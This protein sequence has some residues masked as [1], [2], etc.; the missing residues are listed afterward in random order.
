MA[1]VQEI[2]A[3]NNRPGDSIK[4]GEQTYGITI[5]ASP[6]QRL[7]EYT[8]LDNV[9]KTKAKALK[10]KEIAT[11][12]GK[13]MALNIN[14]TNK[15]IYDELDKQKQEILYLVTNNKDV[16]DYNKN[17]EANKKW[18]ELYGQFTANREKA[19]A[20]DVL[21]NNAVAEI[22]KLP[23]EQ[24][25][26]AREV[27]ENKRS[28][29][30]AGGASNFLK[31]GIAELSA[32]KVEPK[33]F[34][35]PKVGNIQYQTFQEGGN[36]NKTY[37]VDVYDINSLDAASEQAW[38]GLQTDT[39]IPQDNPNNDKTIALQ[40][41]NA[42]IAYNQNRKGLGKFSGET[43]AKTN[44]IIS[45]Y[46][47]AVEKAKTEG[48]SQPQKP[49]IIESIEAINRNIEAASDALQRQA[50]RGGK[51]L[52]PR[53]KTI[54]IE[55]ELQGGE[56]VKLESLAEKPPE[57][58]IKY[59]EKGDDTGNAIKI[60]AQNIDVS[61]SEKDRQ[62][63]WRIANI[64]ASSSGS[65]KAAGASEFSYGPFASI[66]ASIGNLNKTVKLSELSIAQV[67][68]I[69]PAYVSEGKVV[70]KVSDKEVSIGTNKAGELTI[71]E[72]EKGKSTR[73]LSESKVL[74]NASSWLATDAKDKAKE[75]VYLFKIDA[76]NNAVG[77][78]PSGKSAAEPQSG[79]GTSDA[80]KARLKKLYGL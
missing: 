31:T 69:N 79:T 78:T 4:G 5:D 17:P 44:L 56:L 23:I 62:A 19:T 45:E 73:N 58:F 64:P 27:L 7:A 67:A 76:F 52:P 25:E 43:L 59:T 39:F 40:N 57:S 38:L 66:V 3:I 22:A 1:S 61:E 28:I 29:A 18:Q 37:D 24:Q 33:D 16:F 9:E 80:E 32:I 30:L 26:S 6:F 60:R 10:D 77:R 70:D 48:G 20:F 55:D 34:A 53:F 21:N 63:R 14:T 47:A 75:D 65:G 13:A 72:Y 35:I 8:Y 42:E 71:F 54:N 41:R 68:A 50:Q 46:K 15:E 51:P 74:S 11:E 12:M 49:S 36:A 2:L